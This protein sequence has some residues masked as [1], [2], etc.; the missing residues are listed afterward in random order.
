MDL[1]VPEKKNAQPRVAEAGVYVATVRAFVGPTDADP[2]AHA[3]IRFKDRAGKTF[4]DT[5]SFSPSEIGDFLLDVGFVSGQAV[6]SSDV[7]GRKCTVKIT[8]FGGRKSHR[9]TDFSPAR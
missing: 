2:N 9:I 4:T 7:I 8:T 5:V 1:I 6:S 3:K